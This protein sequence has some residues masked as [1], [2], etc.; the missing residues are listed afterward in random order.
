M[1]GRLRGKTAL[2]TAAG[3]GIGRATALAFSREGAR[4]F[5]TNRTIPTLLSL[6]KEAPEVEVLEF[7]VTDA[8]TLKTITAKCPAPDI[9]VNVAG[10]VHD[11]TIL[12]C[13]D[14]DWDRSI[15]IN[16]TAMF[17]LTRSLLPGMIGR[18][19]G[20]IINIAS[21]AGAVKG[22][23][24]R[25]AYGTTKAAVVG[26]TRCLAS[27]FISDGLRVNVICPGTIDTPSLDARAKASGDYTKTRQAFVARQPIGRLGRPEE[28]AALAVHLGSDE[29]AFT[30]GTVNVVDGGFSL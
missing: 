19:S 21:V 30:T 9:L 11:G 25:F 6:K 16:L 24:S 12:D 7:D 26:F 18:G 22:V 4:V 2:I 10:Y 1:V 13:A 8:D 17:R 5:A 20:S 29:S 14:D 28:V 23:P 27:D 3:A 15:E